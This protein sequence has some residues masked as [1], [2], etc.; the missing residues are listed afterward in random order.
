[1]LYCFCRQHCHVAAWGNCLTT[2]RVLWT[3]HLS[4]VSRG[5]HDYLPTPSPQLETFVIEELMKDKVNS[6]ESVELH[7]NEDLEKD[8]PE[9]PENITKTASMSVQQLSEALGNIAKAKE[10]VEGKVES[11]TLKVV[12]DIID[13]LSRGADF[14]LCQYKPSPT[15]Q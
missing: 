6:G 10:L 5:R 2:H 3:S 12:F 7:I 15:G 9:M 1:M 14:I 13:A 8:K 4:R 11:D